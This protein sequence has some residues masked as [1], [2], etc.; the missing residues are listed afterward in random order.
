M[1]L[2]ITAN[3][4]LV[5]DRLQQIASRIGDLSKPMAA[6]GIEMESRISNRFESQSDPLGQKWAAWLPSTR[7]TYPKDGHGSIL[8]RYGDMLAS[9]SH[10]ADSKSVTVGFGQPYAAY[11]EWGTKHMAR[12][13]L[14]FA[15]PNAGTLA[16]AARS[17][18]RRTT[19][20]CSAA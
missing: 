9:L 4:P 1:S 8:D 15:D 13:G 5:I 20:S 12:R 7:N 2:T 17:S 6:I 11:H 16:P 3:T 10:K 14:L 18:M 19:T